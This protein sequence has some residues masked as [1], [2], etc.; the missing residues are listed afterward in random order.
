MTMNGTMIA[1]A[2]FGLLL[3]AAPRIGHADDGKATKDKQEA[4]VRC[5]GINR[6]KGQGA[7]ASA[8][9]DCAGQN[10]CKGQGWVTSTAKACKAQGGKI[11]TA[12]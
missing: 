3:T 4:S 5:E 12:K 7:C 11:L 10:G 2:V 8:R 1:T 9:N 6:C